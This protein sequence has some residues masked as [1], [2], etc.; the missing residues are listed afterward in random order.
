MQEERKSHTITVVIKYRNFI[1]TKTL[2]ETS[3]AISGEKVL[4]C[5]YTG[6]D[7]PSTIWLKDAV[8]KLEDKVNGV[9]W[10]EA[11][12]L[13]LDTTYTGN[14]LHRSQFNQFC[15]QKEQM[16]VKT[17]MMIEQTKQPKIKIQ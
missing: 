13:K 14:L 2:K 6:Q 10:N 7:V 3:I 1:D 16:V 5:P 8:E 12:F 15:E 9:N 17:V 4:V 11:D